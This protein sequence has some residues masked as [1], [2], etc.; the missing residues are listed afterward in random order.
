VGEIIMQFRGTRR[1]VT[2]ALVAAIA[3]TGCGGSS[4]KSS[5]STAAASGGSSASWTQK[6]KGTSLS[7]IGEAT[8]NT[9][10]LKELVPQFTAATGIEVKIEEAPYDQVLQ[11]TTLDATSKSG[12]YDV[13]SL[14][15]EFLGAYA[16]KKWIAPVDDFLSSAK[17]PGFDS[18]DLIPE[19]WTAS[20]KWAGKT[21]GMPSNSAVM[22]MFYRK[23]LFSDAS[24]QAA[25]KAKY[26]YDLA[27]PKTW[28]Q[29]RDM[30]EF[31]NRPA[32]AKLAGQT[33]TD[34]FAGVAL[35]GKRH[36][37]TVLEWMDYAWTKGGGIFDK[38]GNLI[39]NS[40][41]S[42]DALNYELSL[43]KFAQA[44]FTSATW[45]ETTAA[46]QKG[47]AA[48]S[49][50]WGDTA[51]AMEDTK[52]SAVVGKM[53]YASIPVDKDGDTPIAHLGSWTHVISSTSKKKEAGQLFMAWAASKDV[54]KQLGAKGGLPATTSSFKDPELLK[55]LPYW[56]Q[57][58]TS[59][60][61]AKNRPRLPEWGGISDS[62]Q[63]QVS[64]VLSGQADAKTALDAAQADITKLFAG[65][66]PAKAT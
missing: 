45:D 5:A 18:A 13:I 58:L 62:L 42:I 7:Y 19:L 25:F 53:G 6:Y 43:T 50:T 48:L 12:A 44:G 46:L 59:L 26:N 3:A 9:A 17:V 66:L 10:V 65:R 36:V 14:P 40:P 1:V 2:F 37:A 21:Y 41:Q 30:A 22:M 29:Y 35:A 15:Y 54:Q 64:N 34:A 57:E 31:F 61:Q 11:K 27:A 4:S 20:S 38:D 8:I 56:T 47:T 49:I 28:Q 39:V 24:E 23:D 51:G 33:L 32:G 55:S 16:E 52:A 60:S 63:L